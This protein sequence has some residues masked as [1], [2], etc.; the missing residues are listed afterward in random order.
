M[1]NWISPG[2]CSSN[3]LNMEITK[4]NITKTTKKYPDTTDAVFTSPVNI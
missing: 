4:P 1:S 2:L 3:T